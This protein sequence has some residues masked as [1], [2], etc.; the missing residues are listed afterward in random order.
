MSTDQELE[1]VRASILAS[2][3]VDISLDDLR[4]CVQVSAYAEH[5]DNT[6][7]VGAVEALHALTLAREVAKM[8]LHEIAAT[9]VVIRHRSYLMGLVDGAEL[10]T[11]H[12]D[13]STGSTE[14]SPTVAGAN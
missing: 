7:T 12:A 3:G 8:E 2:S 9:A 1:Q 5:C 4:L 6:C 13:A 10:A 14:D 11:A